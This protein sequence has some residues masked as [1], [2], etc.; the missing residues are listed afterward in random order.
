MVRQLASAVDPAQVDLHVV[1]TRPRYLV[2]ATNQLPVT[3]HPIGYSGAGFRP[4]DRAQV[5]AAMRRTVARLRPDVIQVHSGTAWFALAAPS[6][7]AVLEVHDAP[8]SGRH[9]RLSDGFEGRWAGARRAHVVC[10]S[11]SVEAEVRRAW[12]VPENRLHRFPLAVDTE[13]FRPDAAARAAVRQRLAAPDNATIVVGIGRF[14]PSKRFVELVEAVGA[15]RAAGAEV[16]AVIVGDG[17]ERPRIEQV[18]QRLGLTDV[19]ALVGQQFGTDLVGWI[20]GADVLASTSSYEGFGLT[21]IEAA[22]CGIPAVAVAVGGVSDLIVDGVTGRLVSN[23]VDVGTELLDVARS[24]GAWVQRGE[25]A[26]Q[27]ALDLYSP[28]RLAT[29]FTGVYQR[30][31]GR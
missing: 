28:K 2:D 25:A 26:R 7:P 4:K 20:N 12:T 19:V 22:A 31:A 29:E 5:L 17:P 13:A 8:G 9:G 16:R 15:A 24:P 27:R 14:A 30:A 11:T 10:H 6:I 23:S 21:I 18:R 1:T 3:V